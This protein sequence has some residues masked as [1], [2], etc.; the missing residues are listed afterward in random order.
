MILYAKMV[1]LVLLMDVAST[2]VFVPKIMMEQIVNVSIYCV[3]FC[4]KQCIFCDA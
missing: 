3:A 2:N 4:S 1:A